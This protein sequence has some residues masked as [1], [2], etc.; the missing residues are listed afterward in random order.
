MKYFFYLFAYFYIVLFSLFGVV[1]NEKV[2]TGL[3]NT[4]SGA[5]WIETKAGDYEIVFKDSKLFNIVDGI[6]DLDISNIK[7]KAKGVITIDSQGNKYIEITSFLK[8][9]SKSEMFNYRY[10]A[11]QNNKNQNIEISISGILTAEGNRYQIKS[12]TDVYNLICK[13]SSLSNKI[14]TLAN[15]DQNM[16]KVNGIITTDNEENKY[17]EISTLPDSISIKQQIVTEKTDFE[18]NLSTPEIINKSNRDILREE[19]VKVIN[20]TPEIIS[21]EQ[22]FVTKENESKESI[23]SSETI[24]K[25]PSKEL[26]EETKVD[27]VDL[28]EKQRISEEEKTEKLVTIPEKLNKDLS[29]NHKKETIEE[30][31]TIPEVIDNEKTISKNKSDELS[32]D[33]KKSIIIAVIIVF[34]IILILGSTKKVV[35]YYN[36]KDFVISILPFLSLIIGIILFLIYQ[37]DVSR[38]LFT[39]S[40]YT[41]TQKIIFMLS[42]VLAILSSIITI[43]LSIKYNKNIFIGMIIG[44]F[45]V[46]ISCLGVLIL[47]FQF[48]TVLSEKSSSRD[49]IVATMI[50]GSL[51]YI[52]K[53]LIN[54]EEVYENKG[55][56]LI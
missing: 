33:I 1:N 42:L 19:T 5:Y 26:V 28:P 22:D 56:E 34:I 7:V 52:T 25:N 6:P 55:W 43:V 15:S 23:I 17:V 54:G 38:N 13:D 8:S 40:E 10:K 16:V 37:P 47:F 12:N 44:V 24:N 39:Y 36:F 4:G 49:K 14:S 41:G 50:I 9:L 3:L 11:K 21:K 2:I 18:E 45:K 32:P 31:T 35:I 53:S 46:I 51:I 48:L 20:T 29:N 27:P 30:K